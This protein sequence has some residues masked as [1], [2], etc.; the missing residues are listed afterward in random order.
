MVEPSVFCYDV[1]P[2]RRSL[3]LVVALLGWACGKSDPESLTPPDPSKGFQLAVGIEVPKGTEYY[4][5]RIQP[6]PYHD[7]I[8]VHSVK[9]L[10]TAGTHHMNVT[11]ITNSDSPTDPGIYDCKSLQAQYPGLMDNTIIYASQSPEQSLT[12]PD[13]VAA[14]LPPG[15]AIMTEVHFLNATGE[16]MHVETQINVYNMPVDQVQQHIWGGTVRDKYINI[17]AGAVDHVE[18]TRCVMTRD[19]DLLFLT[20]HTHQLASKTTVARFDGENT[21]EM[22]VENLDWS[23][24]KLQDYTRA[25]IHIPQGQ[26]FEFACHYNNP[27]SSS[28]HWGLNATDEMCQVTFGFTPGDS[29]IECKIVQT[30]DGM[31]GS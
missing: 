14:L 2:M 6:V 12:L 5:C 30:S 31:L 29:S 16:N 4:K 25:P 1:P 26:G 23:T 7:T 3:L 17:P 13:G 9:S 27:S 21:G 28:V 8:A 15:L 20:T 22:M 24:P 19:I 18:W 11:L 10:L